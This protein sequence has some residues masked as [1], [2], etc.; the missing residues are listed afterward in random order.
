MPVTVPSVAP[1][2]A[3]RA[4]LGQTG[5][6]STVDARECG[7]IPEQAAAHLVPLSSFWMPVFK[8][9]LFSSSFFF[10]CPQYN[11]SSAFWLLRC[12]DVIFLWEKHCFRTI[13][14]RRKF[15]NRFCPGCYLQAKE[16]PVMAA[17]RWTDGPMDSVSGFS[18]TGELP[19]FA[20]GSHRAGML[21]MEMDQP[22]ACHS[23]TGSL[24]LAPGKSCWPIKRCQPLWRLLRGVWRAVTG[25]LSAH[26]GHWWHTGNVFWEG[27]DRHD[28][29]CS[30]S[31]AKLR[32]A[33][34]R[35]HKWTAALLCREDGTKDHYQLKL[36]YLG[37]LLFLVQC[38]WRCQGTYNE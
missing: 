19:M 7:Q 32:D 9:S 30:S 17:I 4:N 38:P 21:N 29:A 20:A 5:V 8:T 31:F 23:D 1:L 36:Q 16:S 35:C 33:G 10:P 18:W 12:G 24:V 25:A 2:S 14:K 28:G 15:W 11:C 22:R 26:P 6:R 27:W 3:V 13:S 34:C 37:N